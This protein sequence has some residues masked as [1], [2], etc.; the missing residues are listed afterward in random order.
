MDSRRLESQGFA[1][2]L[3]LPC[4][5]VTR[6]YL[7]GKKVK[8]IACPHFSITIRQR[9][10]RQSAVAGAAYQSGEKLFSE[11]DN[12]TKNYQ[13][14]AGEVLAKGILLPPNAPPEYADRQILW[15]AVEKAEGQW[16]AQLARGIIMAL[17]NEVP[18]AEY[19]A[20]VRDYCRDQ[21]VSRGMIVDYAIH[22]KG[23]GNPHAHILL[24]M[25]A[26]DDEGRWLPK[27]SK[28]YD[29]DENGERLRLPSSEYK[30]HKENTTDWDQKTNAE[31]WRSKWAEAVN[32]FYEKNDLPICV[33]LRSFERQ[34]K[35]QLPTIHLGPAV[36]H[37]EKKGIHTELGDYNRQIKKHN[38][39]LS[40]L[41]RLLFDLSVWLKSMVQKISEVTEKETPPPTILD[42]VNAYNAM[43]KAGR[44]EWSAKG[45]QTAAVNDVKFTAQVFSWMQTTGLT[46]LED[47]R[48][49]VD[50]HNADFSR[51]SEN[52]KTIRRL[53]TTLKHIDTISRLKPI[54][55]QSKRGFDKAKARYA[56]AHKEELEQFQ[57]AVRYLKSYKLNAS[58]RDQFTAERTALIRENDV[59]E[60]K[61]RTAHFDPELVSQIQYRIGKVLDAGVIPQHEL[62]M[63]ERLRQP[64]QEAYPQKTKTKTLKLQEELE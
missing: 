26:M 29:L 8:K 37:M 16:N 2:R 34:G 15:N 49:A 50:E 52:R 23:D 22:D 4:Y 60:E 47:F 36:A 19:E 41:K 53:D 55:D 27:A 54:Y 39:A 51:L 35:E 64:T 5:G 56:E 28:V 12:K 46:T 25:R 31:L 42:F 10:K 62:T 1:L 17:P 11:Y 59:L 13:Y 61:L 6:R 57:K 20:L 9:S 40:S 3:R 38:A 43:K 21:F 48:K 30:S 32:R 24:T 18:K 58:D 44:S 63:H 45:K 14:K 7:I 33:D